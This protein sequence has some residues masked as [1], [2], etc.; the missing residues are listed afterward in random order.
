[1]IGVRLPSAMLKKIDLYTDAL[2]LERSQVIRW[3]LQEALISWA[4]LIRKGK[5][6]RVVDQYVHVMREKIR[7]MAATSAAARAAAGRASPAKKRAAEEK[8]QRTTEQFVKAVSELREWEGERLHYRRA[9]R[10]KD[11][12]PPKP[13]AKP[14]L[15]KPS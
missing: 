1:M 13:P 5:G 6:T 2:S 14:A 11:V 3:L 8:F 12:T 9:L 7:A 10:A 15:P 4:W